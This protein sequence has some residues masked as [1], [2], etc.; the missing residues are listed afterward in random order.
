MKILMIGGTGCISTEVTKRIAQTEGMELFL[1]NRGNRSDLVPSNVQVLTGD[2]HDESAMNT[3]L[4]GW[5]FDVVADFIAFTEEDVAR[6]VRLFQGKTEQ[7]IFISTAMAYQKP[8]IQP[9]MTED[10]PQ[11]NPFSKYAKDKIKC[12]RYLLEAYRNADFPVTIVRPSHTYDERALVVDNWTTI[13]RML[14]GKEVLVQGDGTTFWTLTHS[15]DFAKAFV[16]LLGNVHTLGQ[17][18]HIT[19]DEVLTWNHVFDLIAEAFGTTCK[20]FHITTDFMAASGME[21]MVEGYYGDR[22]NHV[23]LDNSKIKSLVPGF[24]ATIPFREGYR[25][26]AAYYLAHPERQIIDETY[27]RWC[28]LV[29]ETQREAA[30]KVREALG[31]TGE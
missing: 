1:L 20:K 9:V 4:D 2:I 28:D 16:G 29:I 23:V 30:E 25:E 7:F 22:S 24:Q 13:S 17:A 6:D 11:K 18:V 14:R 3:L 15:R 12:E 31:K 5:K 27:D 19:S 26:V 8:C 10:T 21:S